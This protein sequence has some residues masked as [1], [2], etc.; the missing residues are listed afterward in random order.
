MTLDILKATTRRAA[1]AR[2]EAMAA[3]AEQQRA[4]AITCRDVGMRFFTERRRRHRASRAWTST[5][6]RAS[7]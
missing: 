2:P 1:W 4:P 6:R 5:S 7:S 3:V